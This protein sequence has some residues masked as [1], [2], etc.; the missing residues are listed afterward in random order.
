MALSVRVVFFLRTE[1]YF[2]KWEDIPASKIL[3]A[4][5]PQSFS[6]IW[7]TVFPVYPS[8]CRVAFLVYDN[9]IF[10]A[11]FVSLIFGVLSILAFFFMVKKVFGEECAFFSSLIF[12]FYPLHIIQ[13]VLSTEMTLFLTVIFLQFICFYN[14]YLDKKNTFFLAK[15]QSDSCAE[16]KSLESENNTF[17][18]KLE[19]K[20]NT[21]S[22]KSDN[23][24]IFL[25]KIEGENTLLGKMEGE[26]TLSGQINSSFYLLPVLMNIGHL[27]RPENWIL[28]N[29]LIIFFMLL[30]SWKK[31][32]QLAIFGN[33]VVF[34]NTLNGRMLDYISSQ[35]AT[36]FYE[37]SV[38]KSLGKDK[39]LYSG[40]WI[41]LCNN[42][43]PFW[44]LFLALLGIFF[45]IKDK[46]YRPFIASL[47]VILV[48]Y[49]VKITGFSMHPHPRYFTLVVF[50][51][52]PFAL[53]L[54]KFIRLKGLRLFIEAGGS[55]FLILYFLN[56][57]FFMYNEKLPSYL[58]V[59]KNPLKQPFEVKEVVGWI[60][61]NMPEEST[62]LIDHP[63]NPRLFLSITAYLL[64]N[65][66]KIEVLLPENPKLDTIL[67]I[68]EKKLKKNQLPD[69]LVL[70]SDGFFLKNFKEFPSVK[71]L[72]GRIY[73][74]SFSGFGCQ[75]WV[76]KKIKKKSKK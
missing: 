41:T 49:F 62:I 61:K 3:E 23:K 65:F 51:L 21:L 69:V 33:L 17:S 30:I 47:A 14:C 54:I 72:N 50:F 63:K 75:I 5:L 16:N 24:D 52:L 11:P 6:H 39:S 67:D 18:D 20:N 64:N 34:Y 9:Y 44:L 27:I 58:D 2:P 59:V 43:L 76:K 70:F 73:S 28:G 15:K 10:S 37:L 38:L 36:F 66:K 29:I 40:V 42:L 48:L 7:E 60:G 35:E 45:A 32:G 56:F 13:S 22:A 74:K 57:N 25:G 68:F 4:A 1:N 12:C 31:G 71:T 53:L 8:L 46:K 26:N 19:S 55:L